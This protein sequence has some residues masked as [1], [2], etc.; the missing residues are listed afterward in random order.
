VIEI[1]CGQRD[2]LAALQPAVRVGVD[3][4]ADMVSRAKKQYPHLKFIQADTHDLNIKEKFDVIILSG[5]VNDLWDLQTVFQQLRH[6]AA[7]RTRIILNSYSRLWEL[8]LV[9][10]KRLGLRK[11][12]LYQNWLTVEDVTNLLNLAGFEVI[13]HWKEIL[14]P[15]PIHL[16]DSFA[17]RYLVKVWP[18]RLFALT[19]FI[20]PGFKQR[21]NREAK[22][23][24]S[25][26]VIA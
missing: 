6:M 26:L 18:F 15:L 8:P 10:V 21:M 16:L 24:P 11:P 20:V 17:N 4:S 9:W 7:R 25:S 5:L 19:N 23:P 13:R 2:L 1:G 14:W 12:V 3:F 22:I